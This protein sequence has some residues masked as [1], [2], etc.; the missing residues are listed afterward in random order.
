MP[1]I[2]AI[3]IASI[4]TWFRSRLSMQLEF[5]AWQKKRFR[6]YWRRLSQRSTPGRP[7]ISRDV[8]DLIQDMWRSN[9]TWGSPR[10]V[11]ELL[12]LGI[13]V[14]KSTVEK[15]RP[16]T[17]KPSSPTWKAFLS[18][19][20]EDIVAC[21]FFTVPTATFRVLF[22]FIMLAHERR[23]I[24]HFNITEH[25]CCAKTE[26]RYFPGLSLNC[27]DSRMSSSMRPKS[28][29][30]SIVGFFAQSDEKVYSRS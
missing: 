17:R 1:P 27:S 24:V 2:V 19:H 11:G 7:A 22:V 25:L 10:I 15:Y 9:P 23:G 13:N 28:S 18:N 12:K 5:I 8:R 3:L 20:I 4:S 26:S 29:W 6:D 21:D 14:A 16:R 30:T